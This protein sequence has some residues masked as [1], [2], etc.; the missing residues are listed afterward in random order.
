MFQ[1]ILSSLDG[2]VAA[3]QTLLYVDLIQPLLFRF[4]LMGYDAAAV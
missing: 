3:V 1:P 2:L 4:D